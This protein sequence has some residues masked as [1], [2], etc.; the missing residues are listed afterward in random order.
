MELNE[1]IMIGIRTLSIH[2]CQLWSPLVPADAWLVNIEWL[3]VISKIKSTYLPYLSSPFLNRT[4]EILVQPRSMAYLALVRYDNI[5][6]VLSDASP[7]LGVEFHPVI[8]LRRHAVA[9]SLAVTGN[10]VNWHRYAIL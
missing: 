7:C 8:S 2:T 6:R 3:G 10:L 9:S 4:C 5:L 1:N